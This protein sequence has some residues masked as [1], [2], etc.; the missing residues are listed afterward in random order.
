MY[1]CNNKT[2]VLLWLNLSV[3]INIETFPAAYVCRLYINVVLLI[4]DSLTLFLTP[5]TDAHYTFTNLH[6]IVIKCH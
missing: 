3:C 4:R 2:F 5:H 6:L 1:N